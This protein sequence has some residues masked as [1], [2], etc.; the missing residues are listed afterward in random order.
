MSSQWAVSCINSPGSQIRS[1]LELDALSA[2]CALSGCFMDLSWWCFRC[3]LLR[4]RRLERW[5]E[6]ESWKRRGSA[7]D[8][9]PVSFPALLSG[10]RSQ[11]EGQWPKRWFP[12]G[13]WMGTLLVVVLHSKLGPGTLSSPIGA[14]EWSLL[15]AAK[16]L[17]ASVKRPSHYSL[18]FTEPKHPLC[19]SSLPLRRQ[20]FLT[21]DLEPT[22]CPKNEQSSCKAL[23][24]SREVRSRW[25][26]NFSIW[27]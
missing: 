10:G 3:P 17:A 25:C 6:R 2:V 4:A 12:T 5:E 22:V 27:P 1:R 9:L 15:V 21:P 19:S 7:L 20:L 26:V 8:I 14:G 23:T 24:V 16:R 13:R 18:P 11:E